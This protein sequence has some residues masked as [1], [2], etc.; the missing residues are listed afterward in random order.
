[1]QVLIIELYFH[2]KINLNC[3]FKIPINFRSC[4]GCGQYLQYF[5]NE[6]LVAVWFSLLRETA[7]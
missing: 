2:I 4:K 6:K 3:C 7:F 5:S 1:M